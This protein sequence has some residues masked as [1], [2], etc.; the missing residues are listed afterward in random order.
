MADH[1]R[2][3]ES[4]FAKQAD[5]APQ[6]FIRELWDFVRINRKWWLTPIIL[7]LLIL[8]GII[9]IGGTGAAPFIYTLF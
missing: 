3:A 9:L 6:G 1:H 2:V 4:D 8:G 7:T 5:R